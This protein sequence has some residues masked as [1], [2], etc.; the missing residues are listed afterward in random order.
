M[1][2]IELLI[3]M[4]ET[5]GLIL[6]IYDKEYRKGTPMVT[7][8]EFDRLFDLLVSYEKKAEKEHKLFTAYKERRNG[9]V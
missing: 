9:N 1:G 5:L 3:Q 6:D 2:K 8:K 4:Q 7:D